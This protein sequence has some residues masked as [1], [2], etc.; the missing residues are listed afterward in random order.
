MTTAAAS[1]NDMLEFVN[2]NIL[3]IGDPTAAATPLK[4]LLQAWRIAF[5]DTLDTTVPAQQKIH[6]WIIPTLA[7]ESQLESTAQKWFEIGDIVNL[8]SNTISAAAFGGVT[9]AQACPHRIG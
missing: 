7:L 2:P 6:S 1:F 9:H 8:I 5:F 3:E 4:P